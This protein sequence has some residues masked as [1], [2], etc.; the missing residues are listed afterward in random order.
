MSWI[1]IESID[2][3]YFLEIY[4]SEIMLVIINSLL[5]R[6][7]NVDARRGK[8]IYSVHSIM[9]AKLCDLRK[10]NSHDIKRY[11]SYCYKS[12]RTN[13]KYHEQSLNRRV[14]R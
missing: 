10:Y 11:S 4:R 3:R 13:N 14:S 2:A 5:F 12:D 6:Y 9:A 8:P 7:F 1:L